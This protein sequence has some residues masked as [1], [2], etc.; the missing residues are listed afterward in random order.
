MTSDQVTFD[1]VTFDQVT[2]HPVTLSQVTSLKV[3]LIEVCKQLSVLY[4][5]LIKRRTLNPN[6]HTTTS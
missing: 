1:Q 6:P 3:T 4:L 2:Q 5:L